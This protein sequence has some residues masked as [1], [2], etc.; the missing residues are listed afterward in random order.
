MTIMDS[1]SSSKWVRIKQTR[2]KRELII[3]FDIIF[4]VLNLIFSRWNSF[5]LDLTQDLTFLRVIIYFTEAIFVIFLD[6]LSGILYPVWSKIQK[7]GAV[8]LPKTVKG[9]N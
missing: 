7:Y 6:K 2:S 4:D 5:L 3:Y 1:K 9:F 8:K